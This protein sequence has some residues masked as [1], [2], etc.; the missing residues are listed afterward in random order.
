MLQCSYA[1]MLIY[2]Y[3]IIAHI[4]NG[5]RLFSTQNLVKNW[6]KYLPLPIFIFYVSI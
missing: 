6:P 2:S 1:L 4:S 3:D 5:Q